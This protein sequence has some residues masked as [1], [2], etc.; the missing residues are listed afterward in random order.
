MSSVPNKHG[1]FGIYGGRYVPETLMPAL[2][3]L[4][5]EYT[6][7]KKDRLFQS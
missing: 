4:E 7:V 6:R 3:E 2:F 5:Q 1:R